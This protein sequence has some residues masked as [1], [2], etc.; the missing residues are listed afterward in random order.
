MRDKINQ[1]T[2]A[3]ERLSARDQQLSLLLVV[4]VLVGIVGFGGYFLN[5]KVKGAESRIEHKLD[6]LKEAA[7]L[8]GDYKRR[9]AEQNRLT[10]EVKANG[11]TRILSYLERAFKDAGIE[12]RNASESPGPATGSKAVR[13][14]VAKV[15]VKGV[16]IDRLNSLLEKIEKGNRLVKIRRLRINQNYENNKQLNADITIGTFKAA[17]K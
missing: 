2:A 5:K 14:E 9:L 13:E 3:F 16:S 15:S 12:M 10:N 7:R 17:E 8:R 6:Q 11:N 1:V 4:L